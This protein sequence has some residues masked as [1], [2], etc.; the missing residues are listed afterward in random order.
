MGIINGYFGKNLIVSLNGRKGKNS[1]IVYYITS[2]LTYCKNSEID[3][4]ILIIKI[5]I[6]KFLIKLETD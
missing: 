1:H 3:V 4:L 2:F 6:S 5:F